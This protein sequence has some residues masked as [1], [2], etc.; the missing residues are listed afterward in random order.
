MASANQPQ[1]ISRAS[2]EVARLRRRPKYAYEPL[3][4][5]KHVRVLTI[6]N[7]DP[8]TYQVHARINQVTLDEFAGHYTA[9]SYTWGLPVE[10]FTHLREPEPPRLKDSPHD[11]ELNIVPQEA[12]ETFRRKDDFYAGTGPML[13]LYTT[14][15][16]V[17]P[18]QHN[19]SDWFKAYLDG[20][21]HKQAA[22]L[23][24][25]V[26]WFEITVF[27][28]DAI[29]IDQDNKDEKAQQIPMMGE[30]YSSAARVLGWLGPNR[31]DLWVMD[32]WHRA[33]FGRLQ[34]FLEPD[35]KA[36]IQQLREAS[37]LDPSFWEE[38]FDLELVGGATW[39]ACWVAYWAFYRTRKWFHRAWI[40]QEVV[41]ST[42][43]E[44]QCADVDLQ[45]KDM[46][47][48]AKII[49]DAGWLDAL[50]RLAGEWLPDEF[51]D[52]RTRGYGITDLYGLKREKEDWHILQHGWTEAWWATIFT[53]RRRD[54][55]LP[56][57]KIYASL[58]VLGKLLGDSDRVPFEVSATATAEEVY[59]E[60]A[61]TVMVKTTG[62]LPLALLSFVEPDYCRNLKKLPSWMPDLT[63]SRYSE[64]MGG[65][66]TMFSASGGCRSLAQ[67]EP[68]CAITDGGEL[69]LRGF[70][71]DTI[72]ATSV[73]HGPM[74]E[75]LC[76]AVLGMISSLPEKYVHHLELDGQDRVGAVCHTLTCHETAS[77]WR[78]SSD[79][80][81]RMFRDFGLWL[82]DGLGT[83][84]AY[85]ELVAGEP[86]PP[87]RGIVDPAQAR[88]QA[89][90]FL[91]QIGD[92]SLLP[93][94]SKVETRAEEIRDGWRSGTGAVVDRH[95]SFKYQIKRTEGDEVWILER[96]AVPYVLR[97][98]NGVGQEGTYK[99][100]GECYVHG[101][102]YG[103]M[104]TDERSKGLRTVR[105]V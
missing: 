4:S 53:I 88:K 74:R 49:G 67:D 25:E 97:P 65:F 9:L 103:E 85:D 102:M 101:A 72:K 70:R 20:W 13:D 91:V 24:N 26:S 105:I 44:L 61:K 64:P 87:N 52:K 19:L 58:G 59:L 28:I 92:H 32:W 30:I 99:F 10:E 80:T 63:N 90:E 41:L 66:G 43:L 6:L 71:L 83:I 98:R 14:N 5:S 54:C 77:H 68:L 60:A 7:Y 21:P 29:C 45:F 56:E 8:K 12:F 89:T 36:G 86:C 18:I 47:Q 3:R 62:A 38:K 50:D 81:V 69:H 104:V 2:S 100:M 79:E 42:R 46:A 94:I 55:L 27:W 73:Y 93:G 17:I 84:W 33:V 75:D 1:G 22:K 48:F 31:T 82:L 11:I 16:G 51:L 35:R 95:S 34:K 37:F 78:G 40:V 96:G 39:P 76:V 23:S 57:D 15:V